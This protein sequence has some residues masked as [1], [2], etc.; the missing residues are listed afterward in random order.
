M[1]IYDD[2]RAQLQELLD[3]VV[4]DEQYTA[5]VAHGII[6]ADQGTA[7]AHHRRVIRIHELKQYFGVK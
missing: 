4:Q 2:M 1:A 6:Q 5:A 3:L 7:D